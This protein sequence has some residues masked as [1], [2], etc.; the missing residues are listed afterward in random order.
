M[1]QGHAVLNGVQGYFFSLSQTDLL[2]FVD[3]INT[4]S[5]P[6][7][8]IK[9]EELRVVSIAIAAQGTSQP[10]RAL[11]A[12]AFGTGQNDFPGNRVQ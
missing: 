12:V 4:G 11:D 5:Y 7:C 10:I 3:F 1:T 9:L 2:S 6:G 8:G